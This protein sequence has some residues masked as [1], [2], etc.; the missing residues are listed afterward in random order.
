[1]PNFSRTPNNSLD[2]VAGDDLNITAAVM[3]TVQKQ[4]ASY[5]DALQT[6]RDL[7]S[8]IAY[9]QQSEATVQGSGRVINTPQLFAELLEERGIP[10]QLSKAMAA[11]DFQDA[12]FDVEMAMWTW[13]CC[14]TACCWTCEMATQVT[15]CQDTFIW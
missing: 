4:I 10:V 6:M 11:E 9:R 7:R 1:M 12:S 14:C 5:R 3:D 2:L 13:D 15:G 8:E